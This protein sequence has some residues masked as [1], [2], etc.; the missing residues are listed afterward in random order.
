[1]RLRLIL[2]SAAFLLSG[3]VMVEKTSRNDLRGFEIVGSDGRGEEH[4]VISNYGFYLF[5]CIPIVTGNADPL[6]PTG[7]TLFSDEVTLDKIQRVLMQEVKQRKCQVTN[8]QPL[9]ESTC[10]F[11]AIP[12]IG[13]TLGI[14]WY[15]TAQVSAT[16]VNPA[17]S[18]RRRTSQRGG[19]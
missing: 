13:N 4:I 9:C 16:L 18:S 8:I 15:K 5:N 7:T 11:S 10:Y 6:N 14:F 3:C 2:L 19:R 12:Y 1:M 17:E